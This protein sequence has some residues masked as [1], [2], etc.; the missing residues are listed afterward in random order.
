MTLPVHAPFPLPIVFWLAKACQCYWLISASTNP[1]GP[2]SFSIPSH[3]WWWMQ[4]C[5]QMWLDKWRRPSYLEYHFVN[6]PH[7]MFIQKTK[8]CVMS[9][10][11]NPFG[12]GGLYKQTC[13]KLISSNKLASR[14]WLVDNCA[15]VWR[16]D[17]CLLNHDAQISL[18]IAQICCL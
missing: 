15:I 9:V 12:F 2:T 5:I 6:F 16:E 10:I 7:K 18:R 11:R 13:K 4:A 17:K 8:L 14:L 3:A 1:S